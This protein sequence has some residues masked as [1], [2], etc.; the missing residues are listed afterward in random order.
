MELKTLFT[1][2]WKWRWVVISAALLAGMVSFVVSMRQAPQFLSRTTLIIGQSINNPNP[3]TSQ[4]FLEQQ[5]AAIYADMGAREPVRQAAMNALGLTWLPSYNVR[6]LPE[7]QLIEI[8][9]TDT[10]PVRAQAVAAELANQLINSAPTS[11]SNDEADRQ[12][13]INEQLTQLQEDISFTQDSIDQKNLEL[14]NLTSASQIASVE[15]EI[16]ALENKLSTLQDT[17]ANL[18]SS[19]SKGALNSLTIVEPAQIP[20]NPIGPN[21]IM[22]TLIAILVGALLAVVGVYLYEWIDQT[23]DSEQEAGKLIQ[24]PLLGQIAKMPK[25]ANTLNFVNDEPFSPITDSFRSLRNNLEFLEIDQGAK[26]LLVTSAGVSDG[27]TTVALNL[28]LSFAKADKRVTLIDADF[29]Q[30][31][32][33]QKLGLPNENG[34]GNILQN[35][36]MGFKNTVIPLHNGKVHLIP[37]GKRPNNPSELLSSPITQQ[38][39]HEIRDC[40]DVVIIDG[41]PLI[42]SDSFALAAKVDGVVIIVN[43]GQTKSSA[44]LTALEQLKFARAKIIGYVMNGVTKNSAYYNYYQKKSDKENRQSTNFNKSFLKKTSNKAK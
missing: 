16:F 6:A 14:G 44:L 31:I 5:L 15:Q 24:A 43:Q 12:N 33:A 21:R 7:T 38:M 41:P 23:I 37:S 32:I 2:L 39:I 17:Y 3:S 28:A 27:K 10:D 30:S 8:T 11:V 22:T 4:F 26:T 40:T 36:S 20:N 18:L 42:T 34:F 29:Y 13:F 25:T 9:V 35:P 19:T 1:P